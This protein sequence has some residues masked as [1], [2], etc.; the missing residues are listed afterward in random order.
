MWYQKTTHDSESQFL[1]KCNPVRKQSALA[2]TCFSGA[3]TTTT[4]TMTIGGETTTTTMTIG[5][6]ASGSPQVNVRPTAVAN[7]ATRDFLIVGVEALATRAEQ[8]PTKRMVRRA[9]R[10]PSAHQRGTP[11]TPAVAI[12]VVVPREGALG[13]QT[14]TRT[15]I[16]TRV[17]PDITVIAT[18]HANEGTAPIPVA[19]APPIA[20]ANIPAIAS[21]NGETGQTTACVTVAWTDRLERIVPPIRIAIAD[22]AVWVIAM[23]ADHAL[24]LRNQTAARVPHRHN[25]PPVSAE[26]ATAADPKGGAPAATIATRTATAAGAIPDTTSLRTNATPRNQTAMRV[27]HRRNAPPASA[28]AATAA[29]PKGGAPAATIATRTATAAD[30]SLP[31]IFCRLT[32]AMLRQ[33]AMQDKRFTGCLPPEREA[34]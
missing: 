27:P 30:A 28:K 22:S 18:T 19:I 15:A 3:T 11:A 1:I 4:T 29:D 12:I 8:T 20:Y 14:V 24:W 10:I 33:R 2:E 9:L 7:R 25:A 34:A 23:G 31:T 16:A 21:C 5:D 26:A 6:I 13:A 32:S 17:L